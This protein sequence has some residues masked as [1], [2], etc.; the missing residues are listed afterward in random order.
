MNIWKYLV[1]CGTKERSLL[2][3]EREVQ[4]VR[5]K[6]YHKEM[7]GEETDKAAGKQITEKSALN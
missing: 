5:S 6:R 7:S 4:D 2:G 1:L 3:E